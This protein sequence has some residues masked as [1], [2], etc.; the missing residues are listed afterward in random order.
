MN[1]SASVFLL[2][3]WNTLA[4]CW[5]LPKILPIGMSSQPKDLCSGLCVQDMM[6]PDSFNAMSAW[7][8]MV[9]SFLLKFMPGSQCLL[10]VVEMLNQVLSSSQI[11]KLNAEDYVFFMECDHEPVLSLVWVANVFIH[12]KD[13]FP[14][15]WHSICFRFPTDAGAKAVWPA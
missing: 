4:G 12:N 10:M 11:L 15:F 2:W 9:F 5:S 13:A 8:Y 6:S 7:R 3:M 14:V 1:L